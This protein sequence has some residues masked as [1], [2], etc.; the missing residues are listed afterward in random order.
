MPVSFCFRVMTGTAPC[1]V[2]VRKSVPKNMIII[3]DSRSGKSTFINYFKNINYIPEQQIFRGTVDPISETLFV[4]FGN[5][6]FSLTIIDTPGFS[7]L[8]ATTCRDDRALQDLITTFVKKDITKID[9]V[10]VAINEIGRAS[11][12]ER[13]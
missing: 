12:R 7:E 3:G 1:P 5:E 10:L 8:S 13:V 6:H 4:E 11:C 9:L 2:I